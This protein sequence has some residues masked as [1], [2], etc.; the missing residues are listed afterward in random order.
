MKN[1]I[2]IVLI[3]MQ[4]LVLVACTRGG[5]SNIA[6]AQSSGSTSSSIRETPA[7]DF[8]Y[9][10]TEDGKGIIINGYTGSG[11][12]VVVP[13]S[14]E[15]YP[16]TEIKGYALRGQDNSRYNPAN[17][18]TEIVIPNSV[19]TIG[20]Y[21]F[22]WID[23]LRSVTLPDNLKIIPPG[24]CR[25][26]KNLT[27]INLPASLTEIRQDAFNGCVELVNLT[28]PSSLTS[29]KFMYASVFGGFIERPTDAFSGC[30][31]LPIRT[32]QAIQGLGY[33]DRF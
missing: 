22:Y 12:R 18:I 8:N 14:I 1:F 3:A 13:S 2:K 28:I 32:R 33:K 17:K 4:V 6:N 11:G 21:A 24:L 5:S 27:T 23:N 29:V 26:C 7:S 30:Q 31:K 10:L 25:N 9:D 20:E 19:V 16:V 15:G